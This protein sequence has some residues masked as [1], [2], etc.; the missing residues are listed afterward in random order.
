MAEIPSAVFLCH[1][2]FISFMA[3][4]LPAI[5]PELK[6][7]CRLRP[8]QVPS[9]SISSPAKYNPLT[10]FDSSVLRIDL[11][12]RHASCRYLRVTPAFGAGDCD[13]PGFQ[14]GCE[15]TD[16][17][18]RQC[19]K[20]EFRID[21]PPSQISGDQFFYS[22]CR[23]GI[24]LPYAPP[25]KSLRA[26]SLSMSSCSEKSGKRSMPAKILCSAFGLK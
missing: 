25:K 18:E 7:H 13:F 12:N 26:I 20:R 3:A 6:A 1:L 5:K 8:P 2:L 4:F 22:T 14:N 19:Q 21:G 17:C 15:V 24:P 9:T 11:R 16:L 23:Q 10:S